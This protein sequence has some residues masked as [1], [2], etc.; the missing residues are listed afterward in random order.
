[1]QRFIAR[2]QRNWRTCT[3]WGTDGAVLPDA[4]AVAAA[5]APPRVATAGHAKPK[6]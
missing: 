3:F 5:A 4:R 1:M 6:Q 2:G